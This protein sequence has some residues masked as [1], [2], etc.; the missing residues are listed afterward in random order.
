MA[1]TTNTVQDGSLPPA[2]SLY[3]APRTGWLSHMP[4]SWVPYIQLMRLERPNGFYYFYLPHLFGTLH[5]STLLKSSVSNLLLTN[6]VIFFATIVMRGAT[7]TWNDIVDAPFDR[8]VPRCRNRPLA[9]RAVSLPAA[10]TFMA[11]QSIIAF[12]F[13]YLLPRA[14]IPYAIP[15]IIG[16]VL[17]PLAK[18]VTYYPQVVLGFPMAWGVLMGEVAMGLDPL[19]IVETDTVS[20]ISYSTICLYMAN[21]LWTLFYEIIYSHQDAKY[22]RQAGVKNIVLLYDG[23]MKPLLAKLAVGQVVFLL[24]AGISGSA[25]LLYFAGSVIGVAL[26]LGTIILKV[27]LDVPENCLWWF[28][29]GCCWSTGGAMLAGLLADY[30]LTRK[31]SNM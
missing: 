6:A 17:Y 14:C 31:V 24:L 21:V 30:V 3:Q 2:F 5:A 12:G 10:L 11:T 13:F 18:R 28:K 1:A 20:G 26:T 16:W 29:T 27:K 23:H 7:C 8:L 25:G 15:A 4:A 9:R 22:D 19:G